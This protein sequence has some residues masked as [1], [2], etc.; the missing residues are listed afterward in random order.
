MK[1]EPKKD[2]GADDKM[3]TKKVIIIAIILTI[4][5]CTKTYAMNINSAYD[6]NNNSSN[7]QNIIGIA[8]TNGLQYNDKYIIT[9]DNN[10]HYFMIW[11]NKK[12]WN[13][14]TC[15]NCKILEYYRENNYSGYYVSNLK[16]EQANVNTNNYLIVSNIKSNKSIMSSEIEKTNQETIIKGLLFFIMV[17]NGIKIFKQIGE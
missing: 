15:E 8:K 2:K 16:E 7:I 1:K 12:K 13:N 6:I 10:Q 17:F 4:C 11:G 5:L 9:Q 14:T 3:K